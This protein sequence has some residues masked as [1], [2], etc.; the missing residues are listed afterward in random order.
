MP[1]TLH[2]DC[3]HLSAA[4]KQRILKAGE[5]NEALT[6]A[7]A[8]EVYEAHEGFWQGEAIIRDTRREPVFYR[9]F[10]APNLSKILSKKNLQKI[11]ENLAQ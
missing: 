9:P 4:N 6:R 11:K 10:P 1:D 7:I 2:I 3:R 5:G 8:T